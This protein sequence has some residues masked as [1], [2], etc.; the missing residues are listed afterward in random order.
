MLPYSMERLAVAEDSA[1]KSKKHKK[2]KKAQEE[3]E[4]ENV[5]LCKF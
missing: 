2:D 4:E 5:S 1:E 3:E